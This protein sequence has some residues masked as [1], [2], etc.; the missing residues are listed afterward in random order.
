MQG[1]G[2]LK[3]LGV[4]LKHF[5]QREITEQYPDV[6]PELPERYRGCLQ[7]DFKKCIVC[8]ICINTCPNDVLSMETEK[9]ENSKKKRL[10]SYTIDFQYCMFC[11]LCVEACPASCLYFNQNFELSVYNRDDIRMVY[12][13]PADMVDTEEAANDQAEDQQQDKEQKQINAMITALNKNPQKI[14][15]K[16]IAGEEEVSILAELILRDEKIAAKIAELMVKDK[17]KAAKVAAGFVNK[18]KKNRQ[19]SD[20]V[21]KGGE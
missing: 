16:I 19:N 15:A 13:R 7:Y 4:T 1:T 8:G 18:E 2:L 9:V 12:L 14:V 20:P 3:G 10:L 11:N 21:P 5:F 6:M 17:E